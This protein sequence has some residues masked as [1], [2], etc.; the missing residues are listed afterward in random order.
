[1]LSWSEAIFRRIRSSAEIPNRKQLVGNPHPRPGMYKLN[2][3]GA[4][5]FNIQ[6]VGIRFI[7]HDHEGKVALAASEAEKNVDNPVVIEALAALWSLRLCMHNGFTNIIIK[8]DCLLL[9][10]EVLSPEAPNLALINIILDII[11]LMH[12][13][14]ICCIEN[15]SRNYNNAAHRLACNAWHIYEIVLWM[16]EIPPFLN[17]HLV[18]YATFVIPFLLE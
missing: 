10:V 8:S 11:E 3:D 15:S 16:G 1:M 6:N 18:G 2:V 9:V 7:V 5:F 4:L 14:T 17:T 12:Y 13:F